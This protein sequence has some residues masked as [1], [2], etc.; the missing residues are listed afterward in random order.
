MFLRVISYVSVAK[1]SAC[2]AA[3]Q[4]QV[5]RIARSGAAHRR[6]VRCYMQASVLLKSGLKC[7]L[8]IRNKPKYYCSTANMHLNK[9]LTMRPMASRKAPSVPLAT[10]CSHNT[11]VMNANSR[12]ISTLRAPGHSIKWHSRLARPLAA[13]QGEPN[14]CSHAGDASRLWFEQLV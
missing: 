6:L 8:T 9:S 13:V 11:S 12:C 4:P 3:R 14:I 2:R 5:R 7:L 10:L 1:P